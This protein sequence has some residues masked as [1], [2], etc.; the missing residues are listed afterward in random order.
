MIT[1]RISLNLIEIYLDQ[2]EQNQGTIT[3]IEITK[4]VKGSESTK[5]LVSFANLGQ[6]RAWIAENAPII[7]LSEADCS[8]LS[9]YELKSFNVITIDLSGTTSNKNLV[10]NNN[11]IEFKTDSRNIQSANMII[12]QE[13]LREFLN[14][15]NL[16]V[17]LEIDEYI[18]QQYT[19][20]DCGY[21]QVYFGQSYDRILELYKKYK[22]A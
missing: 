15:Y 10:I 8:P 17:N 16:W 7:P 6:L 2:F 22:T 21:I 13:Y 18:F 1:D 3:D 14:V 19:Y 20:I 11:R 12:M 9:M 5:S 4:M